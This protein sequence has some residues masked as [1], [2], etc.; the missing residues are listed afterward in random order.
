MLG[1]QM[2]KL[3]VLCNTGWDVA[4]IG[5]SWQCRIRGWWGMDCWCWNGQLQVGLMWFAGA[6]WGRARG[7]DRVLMQWSLSEAAKFIQTAR[8][9]P[10]VTK[11]KGNK[12]HILV[13]TESPPL[14]LSTKYTFSQS[15]IHSEPTNKSSHTPRTP[16]PAQTH[17]MGMKIQLGERIGSENL[18][19]HQLHCTSGKQV[20]NNQY[21]TG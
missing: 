7:A 3:W 4:G 20:K 13:F 15:N 10:R 5:V 12:T 9:L 18:F 11:N 17:Q 2:G 16:L 19:L 14:H 8:Q 1:G 6:G 21:K